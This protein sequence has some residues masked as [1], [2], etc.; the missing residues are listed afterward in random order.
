MELSLYL[1]QLLGVV[2]VVIGLALLM[3]AS[4]FQKMY[5]EILKN[6]AL[7]ALSGMFAL[8][9]G[10]VVVLSHNIWEPSWVVII[11][12][13]GW[14]GLVKGVS[15]LLLPEGMSGM[16]SEWFKGKSFLKIAGL[17]YFLLGLVLVYFG[18]F[19]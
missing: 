17:F 11:T 9:L 3:R 12:L 5:Q 16:S 4:F 10:T 2:L 1:A 13:F 8:V 18:W 14:I 15:I 6:E 19:A 7:L